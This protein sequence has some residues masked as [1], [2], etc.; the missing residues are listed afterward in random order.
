[1]RVR[2]TPEYPSLV[3]S[4][5]GKIQGPS[6]KWLKLFPKRHG[7]LFVTLYDRG[8]WSHLAVHTAVCT[9]FHGPRPEGMEVRHLN[10]VNT[11]NRAENLAWGTGVENQADRVLHGT[12]HRGEKNYKTSLTE[13]DVRE[14]RDLRSW[15]F[16]RV[17]IGKWYA[18]TPSSVGKITTRVNWGWLS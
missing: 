4:S 3:I 5:D 7:Y 16:S 8:C 14:I 10:G 6:G 9:A 15:G 2:I 12:D 11:D 18:I 17:Q 1:M 13:Q